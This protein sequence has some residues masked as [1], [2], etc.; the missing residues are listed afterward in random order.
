MLVLD[1]GTIGLLTGMFAQSSGFEVH[2]MGRSPCSL[3]FARTLGFDGVWSE[4]DLPELPWDAVI[5]ASNS[6][7]LPAKALAL[8][9]TGEEGRLCRT[10]RKPEPHRHP[11]HGFERCHICGHF[12]RVSG[13]DLDDR[14]LCVRRRGPARNRG[15][16]GWFG[17]GRGNFGGGRRKD[18][19]SGR[20]FISIQ[21]FESIARSSSRKHQTTTEMTA[22]LPFGKASIVVI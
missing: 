12:E 4:T 7:S 2:L 21:E 8:V 19:G 6:P 1:P 16:N 11:G 18:T 10:G 9:E 13:I 17:S 14:G 15:G 20:R 3:E 5:D 22:R